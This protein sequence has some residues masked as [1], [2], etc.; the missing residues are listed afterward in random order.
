[1]RSFEQSLHWFNARNIPTFNRAIK[2]WCK[3]KHIIYR[4]NIFSS[5]FIKILIKLICSSKHSIYIC[6]INKS[7]V[8]IIYRIMIW[9][10]E[11]KIRDLISQCIILQ[12]S[13]KNCMQISMIIL[14]WITIGWLFPAIFWYEVIS[15]RSSP[16]PQFTTNRLT[17]ACCISSSDV[18]NACFL[19]SS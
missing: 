19:S 13:F 17:N 5:S 2:C 7:S 16:A 4:S 12:R 10:F 15:F 8:K 1:M 18:T 9:W 11:K 6:D 14:E 3:L